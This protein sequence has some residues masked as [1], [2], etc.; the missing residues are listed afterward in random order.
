V[1]PGEGWSGKRLGLKEYG[2]AGRIWH[3]SPPPL[4]ARLGGLGASAGAVM[5]GPEEEDNGW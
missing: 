1:T 3:G 2:L 5:Y 4:K